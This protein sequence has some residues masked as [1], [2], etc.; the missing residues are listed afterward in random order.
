[1]LTAAAHSPLWCLTGVPALGWVKLLLGKSL[2]RLLPTLNLSAFFVFVFP[3]SLPLYM[4]LVH[5]S[6]LCL[7]VTSS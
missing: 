6:G 5:P 4:A 1:M 3:L 7:D 2:A